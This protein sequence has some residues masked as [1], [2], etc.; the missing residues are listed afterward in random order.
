VNSFLLS[1]LTISGWGQKNLQELLATELSHAKIV[2]Q[3]ESELA[4]VFLA[5][6]VAKTRLFPSWDQDEIVKGPLH[7]WSLAA[8]FFSSSRQ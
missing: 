5:R 1:V 4:E 8:V 2:E 6:V 7:P 3:A